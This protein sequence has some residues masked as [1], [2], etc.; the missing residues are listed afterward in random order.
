MR[1]GQ[2][3]LGL[4]ILGV[5]AIIAVIGLVLL[6][7]KASK[8]EGA[9][10][11]ELGVGNVYGGGNTDAY[12]IGDPTDVPY[13]VRGEYGGQP[14]EQYP[15][16]PYAGYPNAVR[17]GGTRVPAYIISKRV[18]DGRKG[19]ATIADAYGCEW[20]LI[21]AGHFVP[22]DLFNYYQVPNKA[23][24]GA[25][26]GF[27]PS[28]SSEPRPTAGLSGNYGGDVFAYANSVGAE[29]QV[30]DSEAKIREN[31]LTRLVDGNVGE[32]KHEWTSVMVNG[33]RVPVCWISEKTFPFPQ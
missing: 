20:D 5:I 2:T 30:P 29:Q 25:T 4:V 18:V 14:A 12:G 27:T 23:G 3:G 19:F 22:H 9:A 15:T 28:S 10:I 24:G 17:T 26:G 16:G 1:K 13:F 6:F 8:P 31:I 11:T 21:N 33:V 7:T 32:E